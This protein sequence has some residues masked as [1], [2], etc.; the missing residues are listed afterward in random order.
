LKAVDCFVQSSNS[1]THFPNL[2]A[3]SAEFALLTFIQGFAV[4]LWSTNNHTAG[5]AE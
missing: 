3:V 5:V 2:I 1:R 4:L